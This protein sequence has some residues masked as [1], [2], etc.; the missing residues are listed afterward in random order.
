[1]RLLLVEDDGMLAR[2]V[3]ETMRLAGHTID[4]ARDRRGT[5]LSLR[6]GVYDLLLLD[7]GLP[8]ADGLELLNQYRRG[9]GRAMVIT[10]TARD[11]VRSRI[12]ALDAGVDDYLIKPFELDELTARVRVLTRRR[13]GRAA[14]VYAHDD[15]VLDHVSHEATLDGDTH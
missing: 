9:G 15:L 14:G 6:D 10:L 1:M 8:A 7:L 13:T 11:A 5:E 12:D 3:V 4:W 2:L